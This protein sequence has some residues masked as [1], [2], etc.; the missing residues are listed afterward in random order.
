L[1]QKRPVIATYMTLSYQLPGFVLSRGS[2]GLSSQVKDLQRDL[3]SLGYLATGIDGVYGAG[4]EAAVMA[5]SFDLLNNSGHGPDGDAPVA[6]QDFNKAR[7]SQVAG[8][9][10]QSL[11]GCIADMLADDSFCRVPSTPDPV[12]QNARIAAELEAMRSTVAPLPFLIG[13]FKQE[14]G[15]KH[16][17][18]PTSAN[19]DSFVLVGLDRNAVGQPSIT[20][21]GYGVGQYTLFHHP[22][23]PSEVTD[24]I[25]DVGKNIGKALQ[26][27]RGKFDR[28]VNGG[29][30]GT[31]AGDRQAE[32][33]SGPLRLCKYA[34]DDPRFMTACRQCL[35][36]AGATDIKA[37][38]TPFYVGARG[39]YQPTQYHPETEYQG[40]PVRANIGCD[41][42]YAVRRY[43]G[44][45]VNSYHYQ[46]Q[47]LLH[48]LKG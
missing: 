12:A 37:G 47:V 20:S 48:I 42:P 28:F 29:T 22:P 39:V 32:Y 34:P 3:R 46:T 45:G 24:F 41:W 4:T 19:D 36:D 38:V 26:E 21:R 44:D 33:G 18:E 11:A 43:N 13:I 40:V 35:V 8:V 5:L 23:S 15:M 17:C 30:P 9:V 10:D 16:F 1:G 25:L 14:S 2:Q 31:R 6:V 27:L 7:V